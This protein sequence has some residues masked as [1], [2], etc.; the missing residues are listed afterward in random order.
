ML[1][2]TTDFNSY[3]T[4]GIADGAPRRQNGRMSTTMQPG[5]GIVPRMEVLGNPVLSVS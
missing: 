5:L 4:V 1:F 2:T 3:V